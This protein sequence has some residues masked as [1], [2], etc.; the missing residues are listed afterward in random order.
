MSL[1]PLEE[2]FANVEKGISVLSAEQVSVADC[3]G[4]VLAENVAAR[5]TQPPAPVSSMDGYAVRAQDVLS[6]PVTL[7][8]VGESQAGGPY[9]GTLADGECVR[10]FTGAPLPAGADAVIIQEDTDVFGDQ[11]TMKEVAFEGKFVRK[12]GLDFSEGD[13]LLHKG[14][15]LSA[16]DVGLLCAMNV[17]WVKVFRR[18]RVAILATGD[19]LVMPGEAV[20]ESQIISSNSLM[21]AAL[22]QA[23]GGI[24]VN[25]G[26]AGDT[27]ESLR[28]TLSGLDCAD[29][30]VTS[31]GV[32]VGEYDLVR[33]VLG[34][35]GLDIDFW[36]IAMKPG[37]P[38]MFGHIGN[39]PAMGLPGNPVSSYVTAFLFLRPALRKMQGGA[40]EQD[41]PV[42]VILGAAVP[43]NGVRQEYMRAVFSQDPDGNLVATPYNKQDSS[44]LANL[45][46]CEGF[47]IRPV[48]A[49]A[50][51]AGEKTQAIYLK[52]AMVSV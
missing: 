22:V 35:E 9:D 34:E 6:Q 46:H 31:G 2:A 49:P 28:E 16:R 50:L 11:I 29:L 12:A 37:K 47:I 14:R 13:I 25:L 51:S 43:E 7:T 24:A 42:Q 21:V 33:K 3:L 40:F 18:P 17:P 36:R 41:K 15:V 48:N 38:F 4:R 19:E 1:L 8:R 52:D 32:S 5:L 39:K 44:M 10:I 26:I 45:A 20:R 30:L 23:M 27:E